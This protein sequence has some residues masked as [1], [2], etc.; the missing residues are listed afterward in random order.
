MFK[1]PLPRLSKLRMFVGFFQRH[2]ISKWVV[3]LTFSAQ[4]A[5]AQEKTPDVNSESSYL[6]GIYY[7][8]GTANPLGSFAGKNSSN[9][10]MGKVGL[11]LNMKAGAEYFFDSKNVFSI[12][13]DYSIFENVTM[14]SLQNE[15]KKKIDSRFSNYTSA[16]GQE[17]GI[18]ISQVCIGYSRL[19][20]FDRFM[21]QPKICLG[22]ASFSNDYS[23][24]Y[25]MFSN[26]TGPASYT[27]P[28]KINTVEYFF[29]NHDNFTMKPELNFKYVL[30]E[31]KN[32]DLIFCTGISYIFMEPTISL[33][34]KHNDNVT[35]FLRL[36]DRI[37]VIN[38]NISLNLVL[39][40]SLLQRN[41]L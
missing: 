13:Y 17:I 10:Q 4:Q 19:I 24:A 36:K 18:V 34:E 20:R 1:N 12:D 31:A 35:K 39:R 22:W 21:V 37:H 27:A 2:L 11:G 15:V 26:L 30:K 3:V 16:G 32:F 8:V 6:L 9:N 14:D 41:F 7:G 29:T 23:S 38:I 28:P 33:Y 40:R 5:F 25:L